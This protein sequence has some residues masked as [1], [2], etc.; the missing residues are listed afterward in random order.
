LALGSHVGKHIQG[1]AYAEQP[2]VV[3]KKDAVFFLDGRHPAA[4]RHFCKVAAK[5]RVATGLYMA[6]PV[7][8]I[9]LLF[10]N[11]EFLPGGCA[12][13]NRRKSAASACFP[14]PLGNMCLA[15]PAE[16]LRELK[17]KPL[18]FLGIPGDNRSR[19]WGNLSLKEGEERAMSLVPKAT[20]QSAFGVTDS[21]YEEPAHVAAEA[22]EDD[23]DAIGVIDDVI[24]GDAGNGAGHEDGATD[25]DEE[26]KEHNL[27]LF[28]WELP[29][30]FFREVFHAFSI[31]RPSEVKVVDFTASVS[32]ALACC[33]DGYHYVG[34]A[35]NE[36]AKK[37]LWQQ[38][39][40]AVTYSMVL[41]SAD[42]F[43]PS[44]RHLTRAASLNGSELSS[45]P[46]CSSASLASVEEDKPAQ[47]EG[48]A[49]KHDASDSDF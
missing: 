37:V 29:E 25:A 7:I 19:G 23:G 42:G 33:R 4:Q 9:R 2:G 47:T 41:G 8:T 26:G 34:F 13:P 40:L 38:C 10:N 14:D 44:K 46:V 18:K 11:F 45:F 20:Y 3:R 15:L 24:D 31:G 1:E 32:A 5:G 36:M 17:L 28:P 49:E 39:L 16:Y 22:G 35:K 27:L 6:R 12:A 30:N 48:D 21:A 43:K